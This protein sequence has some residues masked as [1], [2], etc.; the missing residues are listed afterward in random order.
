MSKATQKGELG[1]DALLTR[2]RA[3]YEFYYRESGI[4]PMD[5]QAHAQLRKT[6]ET[7]ETDKAY[8]QVLKDAV[9]RYQA[10]PVQ[11]D[12]EMLEAMDKVIERYRQNCPSPVKV[13]LEALT[14]IKQLLTNISTS[15]NNMSDE[16][17]EK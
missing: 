6:V 15:G 11:V 12:E 9:D 16:V 5:K 17:V 8:I 10:E 3:W 2:L 1:M 4:L 14:R 7:R 13:T